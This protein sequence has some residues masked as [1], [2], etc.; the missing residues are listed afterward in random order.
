MGRR[1]L[2][3]SQWFWPEPVTRGLKVAYDLK[4]RGY[5]VEVLTGFPN[6]PAGK[7]AEG[8]RLAPYRR[9]EIEGVTIHRVFLYPSHDRSSLGRALNYLSFFVSA[10]LFCLFRSGRFDLIYVYHPP[11]TTGL[12]AALLGFVRRKPFILEVQDLWPDSVAA[13]GMSATGLLARILNPICRFVYRRAALVLGQ[14]SGMTSRLIERGVN[15]ERADVIFNWADEDAAQPNG[16]YDT[17]LLNFGGRFNFVYAGNLGIVQELEVL[18]EAAHSLVDVAPHIQL[19]LIGEGAERNRLETLVRERGVRNVQIR[20]GVSPSYI[21]DVLAAADVL[22]VHLKNDP[23]FEITIPSKTQFYLAMGRPILM[24]VSGE[25]ARVV[26]QSKA[27]LCVQPGD[28]EAVAS[29]M[30]RMANLPQAELR[31]MGLEGR[32]A[33]DE[34]FSFR[35]TMDRI[36]HHID[37]LINAT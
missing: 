34:R 19:T 1:I 33:Y 20:P 12:V 23:L 32:K 3:L 29:T 13:S 16:L 26:T 35:T 14:S 31:K 30:L 7:L 17:D 37:R 4:A 21:G 18:V 6:Y 9:E 28:V 15:S 27:G 8:Y 11:I 24:A 22:V 10:L 36:A 2:Y 5:E 25:A